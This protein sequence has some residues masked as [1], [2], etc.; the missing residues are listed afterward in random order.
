MVESGGNPA[1][2]GKHG[3]RSQYQI[4][5]TVWKA[6]TKQPFYLATEDKVLAEEVATNHL[7]TLTRELEAAGI[8]VTVESLAQAWNAGPHAVIHHTLTAAQKDYAQRVKNLY[9]SP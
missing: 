8:P 5:E 1:A 3:E 4:T 2:I 6:R 7:I 9:I